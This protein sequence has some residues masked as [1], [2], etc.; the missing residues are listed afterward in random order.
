MEI[1]KDT[2]EKIE[3]LQLLEQN[4]Q[5]FSS[6]KQNF[7]SQLL[8]SENASKELENSNGKIYKIAGNIMIESTKEKIQEDL[9]SQK[10]LLE[11]RLKN[12]K[13]QEDALKEKAESIQKE[14]MKEFE[15][16][17]GNSDWRINNDPWG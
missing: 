17:D 2:R 13:K 5:T 6:Q 10:E 8:E 11:L 16:K 15:G 4:L 3:Q 1:S 12:I 7:Q 14:V 9:K